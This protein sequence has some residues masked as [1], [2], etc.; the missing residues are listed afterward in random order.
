[1]L[2]NDSGGR[3]HVSLIDYGYAQIYKDDNGHI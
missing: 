1:M 3:V 2:S